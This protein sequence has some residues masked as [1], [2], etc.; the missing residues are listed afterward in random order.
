MSKRYVLISE[1]E[2]KE[3]FVTQI[4][5]NAL[6]Q[7]GVDNWDWYSESI[8]N[9]AED[10][11]KEG[12]LGESADEVFDTY[13]E[14]EIEKY[15]QVSAKEEYEKETLVFFSEGGKDEI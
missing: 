5:Y 7:G 1:E 9:F 8:Q 3:L 15:I 6:V 4:K 2:L 13:A 10:L 12:L 11:N 14:K